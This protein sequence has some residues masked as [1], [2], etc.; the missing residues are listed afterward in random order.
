MIKTK[1]LNVLNNQL[2]SRQ[3]LRKM[4]SKNFKKEKKTIPLSFLLYRNYESTRKLH[5]ISS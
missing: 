2:F 4:D 5:K 3:I 1:K